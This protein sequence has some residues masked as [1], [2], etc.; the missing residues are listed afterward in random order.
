MIFVYCLFFS[1]LFTQQPVDAV[2]VVVGKKPILHSEILQQSQII[3]ASKNI[4]PLNNPFEI[5]SKSTDESISFLKSFEINL[6]GKGSIVVISFPL[7]LSPVNSTLKNISI[8]NLL[9]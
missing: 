7:P 6:G 2:V 1:I 3:A 9:N 5:I 8:K 4:N